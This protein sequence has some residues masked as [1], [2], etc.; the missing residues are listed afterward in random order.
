MYKKEGINCAYIEFQNNQPC[1]DLIE[2]K[3][4]GLLPVLDELCLLGRKTDTD[5]TYLT[6]INN[7][8]RG[9]TKHF[10]VSRF[11]AKDTFI[12][13]H[14]AG[15]VVYAVDGFMQKNSDKLLPDLESAM[16]DSKS[17]FIQNI[18]KI[19]KADA[20]ATATRARG[21][22]NAGRV[23]TAQPTTIGYKFKNQLAGLYEDILSTNPHYIR[24]VKPNG[25]K[26]ALDFSNSM[27]MEQLKCNGT[28]EMVRIRRE[29]YPMRE[30]WEDLWKH[31]LKFEYWKESHV[32]KDSNNI[33][34][35]CENV[36]KKALPSGY[37]QVAN[38]GKVFL[39]HDTFEELALWKKNI[40]CVF[41]Q[42][43]FRCWNGRRKWRLL[44]RRIRSLQRAVG[45]FMVRAK[46][47]KEVKKVSEVFNTTT[48][49]NTRNTIT[50]NRN[51]R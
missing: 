6:Q 46:F 9:K 39:K 34:E 37:Y 8:H 32:G 31:V 4:I 36:F 14:F 35:S 50:T 45:G 3:P 16:L 42:T 19:G 11:A 20:L 49:H 41:I 40:N 7:H 21:Q 10:G 25:N 26:A 43:R 28:L 17:P 1:V 15:D 30:A 44:R 24:C 48:Q 18:F 47:K 13:K 33:P 22:S 27:V 12:V 38:S 29:G 51:S 23:G 5:A 2:K